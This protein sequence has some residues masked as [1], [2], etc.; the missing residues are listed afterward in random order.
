MGIFDKFKRKKN[1]AFFKFVGELPDDFQKEIDRMIKETPK[2]FNIKHTNGKDIAKQINHIVDEILVTNKIPEIYTNIDD[3]A[4][5]LGIY[6]GHAICKYYNWS[7]K[8]I[9]DNKSRAIV[10]IVSPEKNYSIQPMNY[11][12]KILTQ[13]NIGLNGKNDNTVLLLFNMLENIDKNISDIKYTP[14]S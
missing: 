10:S 7:W 12:L 9:G 3:V 4:V 5:A 1:N 2:N 8:F 14:L 6:Y 13:K 11:M